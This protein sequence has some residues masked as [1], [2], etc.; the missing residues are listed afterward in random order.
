MIH[1]VLVGPAAPRE[2]VPLMVGINMYTDGDVLF[3]PMLA[4]EVVQI[5][6]QEHLQGVV[7]VRVN[8]GRWV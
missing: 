7:Q 4:A 8:V 3:W 5:V 6:N 1:F 2:L